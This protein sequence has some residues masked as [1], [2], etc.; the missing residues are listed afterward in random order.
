MKLDGG[1][2]FLNKQGEL[3]R[4]GRYSAEMHVLDVMLSVC[5]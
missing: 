1:T 3:Q 4:R 5:V 2:S